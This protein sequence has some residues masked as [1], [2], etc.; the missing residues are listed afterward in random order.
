MK[1]KTLS[2]IMI[3]AFLALAV[4]APS[5]NVAAQTYCDWAQFV[6]DVTV[7]D[8]T[9]FSAGAAFTKTW[10]LKNIGS[11]NWTT[12][13]SLVFSSGEKMGGPD[14]VP[15]TSDV[16][17]GQTVDISV[18]LT[19]PTTPGA[20]RGFW[21]LKNASGAVFGIGAT[22]SSSFWVDIK[23]L[24]PFVTA[25]DF[26]SDF[27]SAT[28]HY[29]G[30]PIPC[31]AVKDRDK[32]YGYVEKLDN[33]TLEDGTAAGRPGLLYIME[34][35]YSKFIQGVFPA[36]DIFPGDHFQATIGCEGGAVSCYVNYRLEFMNPLTKGLTT[37]WSAYE[38]YDGR[39]VNIDIDLTKFA[40]KKGQLV[41][42]VYSYGPGK[43]DRSL[44]VAPRLVRQVDTVPITPTPGPSPT[45]V[46]VNTPVTTCTDRAKFVADVTVPDWT[47]FAPN[48]PFTKTWRLMNVGT[49]TWTTSY[50][51]VFFSGNQM[52]APEINP[53]P[54]SVAPG[55]TIDLSLNL[56]APS[57]PASYLSSWILKN[58]KKVN[59]GVGSTYTTP[60][61]A[62]IKV[63]GTPVATATIQSS[64][65]IPAATST[66][67][68]SNA[69]VNSKYGFTFTKPANSSL[70]TFSDNR[71]RLT[72]PFTSGTNLIEKYLDVVVV[73]GLTQ[74]KTTNFTN[75]PSA[76][77]NVT[78]NGINFLVETGTD[79]AL[80]N[81]YD[82][83]AYSTVR[84]T[85]CI[86]MNF[87]LHSANNGAPAFD[88]TS[89][90]SAFDTLMST[91]GWTQ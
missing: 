10:R 39:Y 49:C 5:R 38:K 43:G 53:L 31:P 55:G 36:M 13:Y 16:A 85:A 50:T 71:A 77:S 86:S 89:E 61:Y 42:S 72:L 60:I 17:P 57:T 23:V 79:S 19:A 47:T 73:E 66:P 1:F 78:I 15:L 26:T 87:V 32:I 80:G 65:I 35:G 3:F 51:L 67:V 33:P 11:C 22:A 82:W 88:K 74:C 52:G 59:F 46:V 63:A 12:G 7:P 44:W 14:S 83:K 8:G 2:L 70:T 69:Y 45:A 58:E 29:N 27:C 21:Q 20:Y 48:A 64:L 9:S 24:K 18:N 37:V 4:G 56:I 34:D 30:G 28:W 81:V 84:N 41:L 54:S 76:S 40:W 75:P 6:A 25:Y 62:A 68:S 90:S 91:F